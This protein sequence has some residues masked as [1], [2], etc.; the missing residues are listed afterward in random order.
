MTQAVHAAR[1]QNAGRYC[2]HQ[3]EGRSRARGKGQDKLPTRPIPGHDGGGGE[4]EDHEA[5][6]K[7][8]FWL[9][10]RLFFSARR[11]T[12]EL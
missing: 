10:P 11:I 1:P 9:V 4:D 2:H 7:S 5:Q 12:R 6:A 3:D 8:D